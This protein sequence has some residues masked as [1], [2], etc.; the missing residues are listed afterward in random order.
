MAVI[1]NTQAKTSTNGIAR[2]S[3]NVMLRAI[4]AGASNVGGTVVTIRIRSHA[5]TG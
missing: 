5:A 3:R 1:S 4:H 2:I